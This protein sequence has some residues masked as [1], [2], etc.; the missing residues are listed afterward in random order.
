MPNIDI[1]INADLK[2][3]FD[4]PPCKQ[5]KLPSPKPL[6]IHLPTGGT[7]NAL[8]DASKGFPTDCAMTFSLLLQ[9]APFL[10]STEC[11]FKGL[12]IIRPLIELI[13]ALPDPI[14]ISKALPK[15]LHAADALAPSLL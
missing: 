5:I 3:A 12:G 1:I 14:G 4:L 9:I 2:K 15:F 8:T 7:I 13:K 10:S 6:K 11:L